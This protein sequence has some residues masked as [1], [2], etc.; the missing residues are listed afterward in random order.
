MT[1]TA[2]RRAT[3]G[4]LWALAALAVT[5][6]GGCS[7][8]PTARFAGLRPVKITAKQAELVFVVEVSNP[9]PVALPVLD[10][11]YSLA[12]GG[13]AFLDGKADLSGTVPALGSKHLELPA[14]VN[15][16][17]VM[18][19]FGRVR[20]GEVLPYEAELGLAVDAPGGLLRL[21]V[22]REG[23]LPIPAVPEV[24]VQQVDW[25]EISAERAKGTATL[26]LTN[27]NAFEMTISK[28]EVSLTLA[29]TKV[30]RAGIAEAAKMHARG[31]AARVRVPLNVSMRNAGLGVLR[32]LQG[33][34]Q[35]YRLTGRV[36][37]TT[38]HG[39]MQFD[40]DRKGTADVLK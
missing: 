37:L 25:E 18:E 8:K 15:F 21:P 2:T 27:P 3:S 39:P 26:E 16:Q 5:A 28:L 35:G 4:A 38:P 24:A 32:L 36:D 10:A 33:D 20:P 40:I 31:G 30:A 14:K 19:L 7:V 22:R 12:S 34:R 17:R 6:L 29:G 23:Q 13:K 1:I 9:Y 11:D